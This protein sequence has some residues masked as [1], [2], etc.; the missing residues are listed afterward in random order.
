VS[1]GDRVDGGASSCGGASLEGCGRSID[2]KARASC[3]SRARLRRG[4]SRGRSGRRSCPSRIHVVAARASR[5]ASSLRSSPSLR[6]RSR[7]ASRST[8]AAISATGTSPAASS[9]ECTMFSRCLRVATEKP[10]QAPVPCTGPQNTVRRS[11]AVL[12]RLQALGGLPVAL[13]PRR[14]RIS[15]KEASFPPPKAPAVVEPSP[16]L[17]SCPAPNASPVETPP[18][19]RSCP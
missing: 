9:T 12:D 3:G 15:T 7:Q 8:R 16:L 10:V 19:F 11:L 2:R 14:D 1:H 6:A 17:R 5:R 13:S 18:R 4:R